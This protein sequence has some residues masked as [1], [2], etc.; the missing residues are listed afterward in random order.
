MA[1]P[2]VAMVAASCDGVNARTIGRSNEPIRGPVLAAEDAPGV[3]DE[4]K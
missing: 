4:A 2:L 3:F 1:A